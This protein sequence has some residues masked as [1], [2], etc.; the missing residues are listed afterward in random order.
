MKR[1]S[2]AIAALLALSGCA[3]RA[4]YELSPATVEPRLNASATWTAGSATTAI[5]AVNSE[6]DR[7]R[8]GR[9]V[10]SFGLERLDA[11]RAALAPAC[12][13]RATDGSGLRFRLSC[14]GPVL[15]ALGDDSLDPAF[16]RAVPRAAA[17][18]VVKRS[19]APSRLACAGE[20]LAV[21]AGSSVRELRVAV[22]GTVDRATLVRR[23]D[24]CAD[25][26]APFGTTPAARATFRP[27]DPE[28]IAANDRLAYCRAARVAHAIQRGIDESA[29]RQ[30]PSLAVDARPQ[31][32]T[33][34]VAVFGASDVYFSHLPECQQADR[35]KCDA[36]R[37]VE[38]LLEVVPLA[39]ELLSRCDSPR[40][41]AAG[42]LFCLQ[43]C[44][45]GASAEL[46][47]S[48]PYTPPREE[49][50]AIDLDDAPC[51]HYASTRSGR[52]RPRWLTPASILSTLGLDPTARCT[53]PA[54]QTSTQ[55][56]AT[57]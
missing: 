34:S 44:L 15:F 37:R 28:W 4:P 47:S 32:I 56:A 24:G 23:Q 54:A 49:L 35:G 42:S 25:L 41:D 1:G 29:Q 43:D 48:A 55:P 57:L 26:P 19:A 16:E 53:T 31:T 20:I 8:Q 39:N 36:A 21:R 5:E 18:E 50:P 3:A 10:R 45:A 13:F 52:G 46:R 38:V 27:G 2:P 12:E 11:I 7:C 22:V 17:C 30:Q 33:T 14:E 6:E 51:W 9:T 40:S